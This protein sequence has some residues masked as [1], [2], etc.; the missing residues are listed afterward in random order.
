MTYKLIYI[1][2]LFG[3]KRKEGS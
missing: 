3:Y 1:Y 2:L